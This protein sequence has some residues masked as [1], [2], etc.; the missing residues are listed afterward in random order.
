MSAD[1]Q[2]LLSAGEVA[3]VLGISRSAFY[4]LLSSGRIGPL[5]MRLGRS[6]RWNRRELETWIAEKCPSRDRWLDMQ[7]DD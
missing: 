7:G 1:R 5:P 2:I 3:G 4:S 6:V